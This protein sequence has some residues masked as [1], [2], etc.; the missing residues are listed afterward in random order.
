V[1]V[2]GDDGC[3][4]M[5]LAEALGSGGPEVERIIAAL[6]S[7]PSKVGDD[8]LAARARDTPAG[9]VWLPVEVVPLAAGIDWA[10]SVDRSW[11]A[12]VDRRRHRARHLL[13]DSGRGDDLEA[14]LHVAMLVATEALD[15]ADDRDPGA[16]AASG[17]QLWLVGAAVAWALAHPGANPFAPWA[18]L[19]ASGLWPIGPVQGRMVVCAT[20]RH[21][22]PFWPRQRSSSPARSRPEGSG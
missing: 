17:A 19:V 11:L 1:A 2:V 8:D 21:R 14:A 12:A 22:S 7:P 15:P 4:R 6:R 13:A 9:P 16:H 5:S 18:E 20:E 3:R 10:D